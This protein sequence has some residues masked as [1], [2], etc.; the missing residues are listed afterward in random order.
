MMKRRSFG[1]YLL[2]FF[3]T[4]G[5]YGIFH[6]FM[7]A[8]DVRRVIGKKVKSYFWVVLLFLPTFGIYSLVWFSKLGGALEE[9]LAKR[10]MPDVIHGGGIFALS[11]FGVPISP[12]LLV[13]DY[14]IIKAVNAMAKQYEL[15]A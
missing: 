1:L 3:L 11:F 7:V 6:Y 2:L 8:R 13:R 12:L 5:L 9:Y 10:G 14:H 4:F 15:E